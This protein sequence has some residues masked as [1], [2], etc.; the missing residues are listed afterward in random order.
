M[1]RIDIMSGT[2]RRRRWS[3]EAKLRILA[4]ADEPGARIGDVA[5]RH[6][7][8]P[9]QIR[10]WRQQ[11]SYADRPMV[12]LPVEITEEVGVSQPTT[13]AT[14]PSIVEILLRNGR[15]LKVP[16]DVELKL[17]GQL[18]ACVEAA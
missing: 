9:G 14:R 17:L 2:E 18:V 11:I 16:A 3:D 7:I 6:D 1:A 10:L 4:E 5:R 13:V 8:H 12:F 15:L